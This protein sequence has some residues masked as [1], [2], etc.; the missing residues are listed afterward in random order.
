MVVEVA[1]DTALR[2]QAAVPEKAAETAPEARD[3]SDGSW[4]R[5]AMP[6]PCKTTCCQGVSLGG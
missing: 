4:N 3:M 1:L 6:T 2:K 5:P